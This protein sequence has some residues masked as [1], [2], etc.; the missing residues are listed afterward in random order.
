MHTVDLDFSQLQINHSDADKKIKRPKVEA[1]KK[2]QD[3]I[4][5]CFGDPKAGKNTIYL[6]ENDDDYK[7]MRQ[8]YNPEFFKE[9]KKA[10]D[11]YIA[12]KWDEAT[13]IMK[14][15]KVFKE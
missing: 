5:T 3:I 14:K 10:F 2:R 12:G 9:W 15:T 1:K 11:F 13:A 6:L 8:P 7:Q 4:D